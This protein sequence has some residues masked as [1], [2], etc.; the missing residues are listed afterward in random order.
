MLEQL[1]YMNHLGEV[2][3]FGKDGVFVNS[4][5]LHDYEWEVTT[6]GNR[7]ASLGYTVSTRSL[8]IIILCETEEEGIKK[9]NKIL[10][11]VEKDVL[12]MQHGR[13]IVG[14]YYFRCYITKSQKANYLTSKR[15][16]EVTLTLTSDFPFWVKETEFSFE[17]NGLEDRTGKNL[18]YDH[19]LPYDFHNEL[20]GNWIV[21]TG[22]IDTNFRMIIH[23]VC[24]NPSV[25]VNG[26]EYR[27][28]CNVGIR[29]TLTIDSV[30]KK[31]YKTSKTGIVTNVFNLRNKTSYIFQKIPHGN[32]RVSWEGNFGV[33][34][35]L[36][37][38]RSEP[39]WT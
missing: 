3:E 17:D 35:V 12:S 23:G 25:F 29:E 8:P 28:N 32:N 31:V 15:W 26:H 18:D 13:I 5:E 6:R 33:D 39:K 4:N 27:V 24:S 2:F 36:L 38:E 10:E 19:D 14:D 22:F 21:N 9:R 7:I 1:S 30:S 16:L 34:I 20:A 11:V 37:E